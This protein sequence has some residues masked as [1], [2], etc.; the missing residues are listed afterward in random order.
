MPEICLI[1]VSKSVQMLSS[2]QLTELVAKSAA[3]NTA[4]NVTGVLLKV[5]NQFLQ[6][7]EG[8]EQAVDQLYDK[9]GRDERHTGMRLLYKEPLG[10]RIFGQWS[11][12]LLELDDDFDWR[13]GQL[14]AFADQVHSLANGGVLQK[15]Q[16]V[17]IVHSFPAMLRV[18]APAQERV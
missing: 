7:L 6:V 1:Y 13:E 2:T 18:G 3:K 14:D 9:I 15:D 4:I 12:G 11:M 5:G 16:I 8:P 17:R 10:E